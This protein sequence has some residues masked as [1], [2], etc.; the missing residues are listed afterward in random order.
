MLVV[1]ITIRMTLNW[2]AQPEV[3]NIDMSRDVDQYKP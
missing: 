2:A 3:M 1:Y